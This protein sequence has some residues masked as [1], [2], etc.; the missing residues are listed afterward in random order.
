MLQIRDAILSGDRTPE[1]YAALP[2]PE[3]YRAAYHP[4]YRV[5]L[6][7]LAKALENQH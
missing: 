2:I 5:I 7:D 6:E 4:A 3:T 1:T